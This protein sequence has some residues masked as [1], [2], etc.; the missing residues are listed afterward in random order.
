MYSGLTPGTAFS[1]FFRD[2]IMKSHIVHY[3]SFLPVALV[4][5]LLLSS[6]SD[7]YL[8]DRKHGEDSRIRFDLSTVAFGT[9]SGANRS[10]GGAIRMDSGDSILYLNPE[11]TP[12][13]TVKGGVVKTTRSSSVDSSTIEDFGVY[14][15]TVNGDVYMDNV[16]VTRVNG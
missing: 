11:I 15:E 13:I 14:A 3:I 1:V 10:V 4:A 8:Y 16:E 2:I 6:C 7:D 5:C 9:R 12:G